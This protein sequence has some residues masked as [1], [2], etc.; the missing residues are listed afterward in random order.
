MRKRHMLLAVLVVAAVPTAALAATGSSIVSIKAGFSPAKLGKPS[1]VRFAV[2]ET[3]PP[4]QAVPPA[5]SQAII[6]LPAGT[7]IN[8]RAFPQCSVATVESAAGPSSCPAGSAAGGGSAVL[9]VAAGGTVQSENA[10]VKVYVGQPSGGHPS[11]IFWSH[12]TQPLNQ[13][14]VFEGSYAGTTLTVPIPVI[15]PLPGIN[16]SITSFS[17]TVGAK[18]RKHGK[19]NSLITVPKRCRKSFKWSGAFSYYPASDGTQTPPQAAT[20]TSAC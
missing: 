4:G 7:V 16:A 20:T 11:L 15:T 2:N 10:V 9:E 12:G 8:T 13:T 18:N 5:T 1:T 17:T 6:H 19:T 3:A 14:V